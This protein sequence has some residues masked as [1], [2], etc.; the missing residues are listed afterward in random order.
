MQIL[1]SPQRSDNSLMYTFSGE[2]VTA[3]LNGQQETFDFSSLVDGADPVPVESIL[4]I[5]PIIEA[6]RENGTVKLIL[7]RFHGA[8]A[9]EAERFPVW[10][11]V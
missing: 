6:R 3:N 7:L 8:N 10:Q 1:Y 5:N 4:P 11:E 9:T 2:T